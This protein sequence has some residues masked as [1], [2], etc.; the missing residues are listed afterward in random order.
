MATIEEEFQ[1]HRAS[2]KRPIAGQSL[3]N[4]PENP[5]PYEK[6]PRFTSVHEASE[7]LWESFIEPDIYVNLMQAVAD[8]TPIMDIVQVILFNEFQQGSW[9]PDLMLML[10]EPAAYMI[11]ALAERIGL[12]MSIYSGEL[13]DED[14]EE[15][16]LGATIEESRIQKII[17]DAKGGAIPE[18]TL[19]AEMQKSLESLPEIN[20]AP[21]AP[22]QPSLMEAPEKEE[23]TDSL[24][25]RPTGV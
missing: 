23:P 21:S 16:I 13:E 17:K 5:A 11:I 12:E 20:V 10:V 25:A 22:A 19:T 8:G 24:M 6:P 1:K 3:A 15:E 2:G 9:N 7:Y 14:D 4:D 18:G